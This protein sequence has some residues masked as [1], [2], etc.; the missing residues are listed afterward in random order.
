MV[1]SFLHNLRILLRCLLINTTDNKSFTLKLIFLHKYSVF[2]LWSTLLSCLGHFEKFLQCA[3][4]QSCFSVTRSELSV[5]RVFSYT[6]ILQL[7]FPLNSAPSFE[8]L[9][10]MP[11]ACHCGLMLYDRFFPARYKTHLY[12]P[13]RENPQKTKEIIVPRLL[14]DQG[15][16]D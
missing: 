13:Q 14:G 1:F 15:G 4:V 10:E 6:G 2:T 3:Q 16:P 9:F 12:S 7:L 11:A 5:I 8:I